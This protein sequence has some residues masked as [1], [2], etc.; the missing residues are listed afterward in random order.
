MEGE[1][2]GIDIISKRLHALADLIDSIGNTDENVVR[3]QLR[4]YRTHP[5]SD[6]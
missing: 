2:K 5:Q 1:V 4:A 6:R 3:G